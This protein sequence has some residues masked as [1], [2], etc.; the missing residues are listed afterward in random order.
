MLFRSQLESLP[1]LTL[2]SVKLTGFCLERYESFIRDGFEIVQSEASH[3]CNSFLVSRIFEDS[4]F[5]SFCYAN[6]TDYEDIVK[7]YRNFSRT[8]FEFLQIFLFF[9]VIA[10]PSD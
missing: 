4:Y 8:P 5:S 9:R 1:P 3:G 10:K 6:R 2:I 7:R